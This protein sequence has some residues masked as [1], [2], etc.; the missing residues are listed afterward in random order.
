MA[1]IV[2]IAKDYGLRVIEDATQA[3]GAAIGGQRVGTYGDLAAS[4]FYPSKNLGA[5]GDG[6][7]VVTSDPQLDERLRELRQYGWRQRSISTL[8]GINSRLDEMQ[9]AILRVKLRRL[10]ADN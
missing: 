7:A 8:P 5:F 10:E 3:H 6:G 4:S 9:A 2:T 1:E